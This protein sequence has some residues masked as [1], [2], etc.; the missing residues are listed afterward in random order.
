VAKCGIYSITN[1]VNGHRYVG[2]SVDMCKRWGHHKMRLRRGQHHSGHLQHAWNKHGDAAFVF[3]GLEKVD[4]AGAG[5]WLM[6]RSVAEA[7]G[8][9]PY[10]MNDGGEDLKLCQKV[11]EAGFDLHIDWSVECL[12]VGVGPV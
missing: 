9:R 3:E 5:C 2:A 12:H 1:T 7:I 4:V 6:H 8:R 10:D 11:R